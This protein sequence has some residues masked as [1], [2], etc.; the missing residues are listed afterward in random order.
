MRTNPADASPP[1]VRQR[2]I[3]GSSTILTGRDALKNNHLVSLS[4]ASSYQGLDTLELPPQG[5]SRDVEVRLKEVPFGVKIFKLV[6]TN[7][8]IQWVITK[9][10][11][12]HMTR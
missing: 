12:A 8:D 6:V 10:L 3:R 4:K 11:A 7:G 9:H 1:T 2:T 5:W